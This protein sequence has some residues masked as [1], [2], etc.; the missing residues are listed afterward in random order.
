MKTTEQITEECRA[1]LKE[2]AHWFGGFDELRKVIDELEEEA[3]EAA[4]YRATSGP[5]DAWSGGFADNH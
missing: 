5:A 1:D 4:Y 3:N 2:I